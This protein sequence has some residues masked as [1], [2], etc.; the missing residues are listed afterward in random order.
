MRYFITENFV[1]KRLFSYLK[2]SDTRSNENAYYFTTLYVMKHNCIL[3]IP[4]KTV[5]SF[6]IPVKCLK[7]F[8]IQLKIDRKLLCDVIVV[9]EDNGLKKRCRT[10][11]KGIHG[12]GIKGP[13]FFLFCN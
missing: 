1:R 3:S 10:E 11:I 4:P 8:S 7:N 13:S 12:L 9:T 2:C 6:L 5:L